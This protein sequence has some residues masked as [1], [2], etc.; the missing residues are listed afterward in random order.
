MRILAACQPVHTAACAGANDDPAAGAAEA[1]ATVL[2]MC[3][4]FET[5]AEVSPPC[6]ELAAYAPRQRP[7][8]DRCTGAG[9]ALRTPAD[10]RRPPASP[11]PQV[12]CSAAKRDY[13]FAVLRMWR[14]SATPKGA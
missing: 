14:Q 8:R 1:F 3:L 9:P 12:M 11:P 6:A 7:A 13:L 5:F 4:E 10:Y 2:S